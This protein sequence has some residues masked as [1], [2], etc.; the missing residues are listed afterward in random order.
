MST[1]V[2]RIGDLMLKCGDL[3]ACCSESVQ[4]VVFALGALCMGN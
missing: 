1:N 2:G 4:S 3:S